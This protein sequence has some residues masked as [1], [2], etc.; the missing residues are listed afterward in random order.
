MIVGEVGR[1]VAG[2]DEGQ[3]CAVD[4]CDR[5]LSDEVGVFMFRHLITG[6]LTLVCRPCAEA[7]QLSSSSAWVLVNL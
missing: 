4:A 3:G 5:T 6:K 1:V 7:L 2:W